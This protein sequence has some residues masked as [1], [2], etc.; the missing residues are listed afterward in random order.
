[1]L[2]LH[3]GSV[4]QDS[5]ER[6]Q[7]EERVTHRERMEEIA[8]VQDWHTMQSMGYVARILPNIVFHRDQYYIYLARTNIN[9]SCFSRHII[10]AFVRMFC[11]S[12]RQRFTL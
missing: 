3:A 1:M 9:Y 8:V 5:R 10:Y 11:C 4:G 2:F 6:E 7:E 12:Y